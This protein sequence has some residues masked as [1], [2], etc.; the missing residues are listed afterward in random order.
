MFVP[1]PTTQTH[2]LDAARASGHRLR[3][4]CASCAEPPGSSGTTVSDTGL[5]SPR[6][7]DDDRRITEGEP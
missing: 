3:V 1:I 2:L 6:R 7:C 4:S 5:Q